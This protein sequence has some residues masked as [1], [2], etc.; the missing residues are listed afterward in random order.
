[1]TDKPKPINIQ[2]PG[3]MSIRINPDGSV[4]STSQQPVNI[5]IELIKSVGVENLLD[6]E[7]HSINR[8]FNST[9]HYIKFFGAGEV[10]FAYNSDGKLLQFEG[11]EIVTSITGGD[12]IILKRKPAGGSA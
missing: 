4:S 6:V 1:V 8:A 11:K 3:G 12:R 5:N 7:V 2:S 10:K 9:S